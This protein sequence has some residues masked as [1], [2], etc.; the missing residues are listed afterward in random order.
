MESIGDVAALI[1]VS[2]LR[3]CTAWIS[4]G[5]DSQSIGE[6]KDSLGVALIGA[7]KAE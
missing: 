3:N 6:E 4:C 5:E 2:V 1:G 7:A